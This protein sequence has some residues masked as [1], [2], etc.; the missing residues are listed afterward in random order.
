MAKV[1]I[2][3]LQVIKDQLGSTATITRE[4]DEKSRGVYYYGAK[5]GE[6]EYMVKVT[7][8][9]DSTPWIKFEFYLKE[10]HLTIVP[11]LNR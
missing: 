9:P 8:V 7:H 10:P 4:G 5:V 6:K 1:L 2:D 11:K 3:Y